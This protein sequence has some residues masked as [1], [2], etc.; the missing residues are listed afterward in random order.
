MDDHSAAEQAKRNAITKIAA[1]NA[2][3][4]EAAVM[5]IKQ[6]ARSRREISAMDVW[7]HY[8]GPTPSSPRAVGAAFVRAQNMLLIEPT[9]RY[10][11]S[12]RTSDHN[13]LL[14]VWRSCIYTRPKPAPVSEQASLF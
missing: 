1:S 8:S 7:T 12:G 5:V 14:R 6:L 3:F 2:A 11:K 9:A 10:V 13:Q 4:I